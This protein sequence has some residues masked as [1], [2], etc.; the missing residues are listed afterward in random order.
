MTE[1]TEETKIEKT[2]IEKTHTERVLSGL[3]IS[4][5]EV[6]EEEKMEIETFLEKHPLTAL[7]R[8]YPVLGLSM[9]TERKLEAIAMLESYNGRDVSWRRSERAG[10][11]SRMDSAELP[12]SVK[13]K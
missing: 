13:E 12:G 3:L 6:E 5:L 10:N 8:D 1:E 11:I 4:L 9:E 2:K 7:L